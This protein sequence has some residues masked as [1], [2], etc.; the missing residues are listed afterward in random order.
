MDQNMAQVSSMLGNLKNMAI[1]MGDEVGRQNRQ[2][3]RIHTKVESTDS[4]INTANKRATNILK[5]S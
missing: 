4:R 1:D 5:N 3:E 2:I